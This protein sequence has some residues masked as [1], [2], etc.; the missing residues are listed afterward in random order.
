MLVCNGHRV[1]FIIFYYY[2]YFELF[3]LLVFIL[4]FFH[5]AIAF[6]LLRRSCLFS[7]CHRG[8][9]VALFLPFHASVLKPDFDLPLC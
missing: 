3:F 7:S 9:Q 5:C 6:L 4:P 1:V 8:G 2:Y